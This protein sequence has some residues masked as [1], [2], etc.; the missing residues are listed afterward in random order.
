MQPGSLLGVSKGTGM[1]VSN[2]RDWDS[3]NELGIL[4]SQLCWK[5]GL[6]LLWSGVWP[7][8]LCSLDRLG[9]QEGP[10]SQPVWPGLKVRSGQWPA[11]RLERVHRAATT[12]S[13]G[14]AGLHFFLFPVPRLGKP[15]HPAD[16]APGSSGGLSSSPGVTRSDPRLSVQACGLL[17]EQ[18]SFWEARECCHLYLRL[19]RAQLD[20]ALRHSE[21]SLCETQLIMN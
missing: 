5:P 2:C 13:T 17:S 4:K 1:I 14:E 20:Q 16:G 8:S 15:W 18:G 12:G 11:V 6:S 10:A 21:V 7:R 19:G 9:P 3:N